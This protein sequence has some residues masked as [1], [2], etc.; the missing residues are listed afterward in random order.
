M[1]EDGVNTGAE[2]KLEDTRREEV[3]TSVPELDGCNTNAAE[4]TDVV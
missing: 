3:V 2:D 1:L 4:L